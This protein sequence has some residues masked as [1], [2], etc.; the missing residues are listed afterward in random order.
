MQ[1]LS[2]R[3]EHCERLDVIRDIAGGYNRRFSFKESM[4]FLQA[5]EYYLQEGYPRDIA[6]QYA[7]D[8]YFSGRRAK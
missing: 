3:K 7:Y 2:P 6:A 8:M 5:Y 4:T 1:T